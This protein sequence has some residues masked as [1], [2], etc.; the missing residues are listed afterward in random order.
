[1]N[2][3]VIT[4]L[5]EFSAD[6]LC[7]VIGDNGIRNPEAVDDIREEQYRLFRF[8]FGNGASLD[9]LGE[10]VHSYEQVRVAPRCL[11]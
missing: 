10:L 2:V 3:V 7:T 11:L 9:P 5:Q 8:D 6:E 4:E 1:M